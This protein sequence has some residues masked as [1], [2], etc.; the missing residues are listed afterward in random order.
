[1]IRKLT[2]LTL[3]L[4]MTSAMVA[5]TPPPDVQSLVSAEN[6][7]ASTT[8]EKG[9][10][11]GFLQVSDQHTLVFRPGPVKAREFYSAITEDSTYLHWYPTFARIAQSGDWGFT[12]GPYVV[13]PAGST[14]EGYGQY[15][16]VWKKN[17][18][19]VWKLAMDIGVSHPKPVA[20]PKLDYASPGTGMYFKQRS[21]NRLQQRKDI[22]A[23]TDEL[24]GTAQRVS[25]T[26]AYKEYAS[27]DFHFLFPGSE[28]L[29]GYQKVEDFLSA[30]KIRINTTHT[31]VDRAFSGDMA[32]T[33]GTAHV[34]RNAKTDIYQYVRVWQ[35]RDG[36]W[37]V[38]FEVFSA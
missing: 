11:K 30:K 36:K 13:R 8:L 23:T 29:I 12:S 14:E 17:S 18:R 21:D 22:V 19:G 34:T 35:L 1:M 4:L 20:E 3:S 2:L 24:L 7:F 31:A 32:Y 6:F 5:Q 33:Y 27:P 9:I 16:S 37:Y 38:I 28:P 26:L 10:K 15:L 25:G